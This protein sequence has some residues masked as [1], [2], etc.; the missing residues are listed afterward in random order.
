[1]KLSKINAMVYSIYNNTEMDIDDL[2]KLGL[3]KNIKT[4]S[5]KVEAIL[6][7]IQN[8]KSCTVCNYDVC[9]D[10]LDEMEKQMGDVE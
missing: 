3:K 2:S 5:K 4:I 1:M 10:C 7:E 8:L 9:G 6:K